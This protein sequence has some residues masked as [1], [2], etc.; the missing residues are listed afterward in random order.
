MLSYSEL[1]GILKGVNLIDP[2]DCDTDLLFQLFRT[3]PITFY[4]LL[5]SVFGKQFHKINLKNVLWQISEFRYDSKG[6]GLDK[7]FLSL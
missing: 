7:M 2:E 5:S 6:L 4:E 3:K 1:N